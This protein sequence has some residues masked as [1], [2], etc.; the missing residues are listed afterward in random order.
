MLEGRTNVVECVFDP[1]GLAWTGTGLPRGTPLSFFFALRWISDSSFLALCPA[2]HSTLCP[3][4]ILTRVR[5]GLNG[6]TYLNGPQ[7]SS[8]EDMGL[9]ATVWTFVFP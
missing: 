9:N 7:L 1:R 2:D 4:D 6:A 8:A 5:V 3:S